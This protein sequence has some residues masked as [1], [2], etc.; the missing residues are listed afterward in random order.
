MEI[1]VKLLYINNLFLFFSLVDCGH[2]WT[3]MKLQNRFPYYELNLLEEIVKQCNG[4][5]QQAYELLNV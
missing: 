1:L 2:M 5:C 3:L 4:N